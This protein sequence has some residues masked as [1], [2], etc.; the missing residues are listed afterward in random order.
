MN[1]LFSDES[2]G[3]KKRKKK[4]KKS[5]KQKKT[6]LR[7][8]HKRYST[9]EAE[10]EDPFD[11]ALEEAVRDTHLDNIADHQLKELA[12]MQKELKD[13]QAN[14]DSSGEED[15]QPFLPASNQQ[16]QVFTDITNLNS[17]GNKCAFKLGITI[18]FFT[19]LIMYIFN[20]INNDLFS[21][22]SPETQIKRKW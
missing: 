22:P 1:E 8:R 7:R 4:K 10:S 12:D 11:D 14:S 19:Y 16:A 18:F 15:H 21:N 17:S 2:E 3:K 5:K 9:S 20:S 13:L 6:K